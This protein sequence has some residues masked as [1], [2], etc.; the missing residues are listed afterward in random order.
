MHGNN[1]L[2]IVIDQSLALYVVEKH[3]SRGQRE[4][5]NNYYL[6]MYIYQV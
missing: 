4:L 5:V 3:K 1:G 2:E 6:Y